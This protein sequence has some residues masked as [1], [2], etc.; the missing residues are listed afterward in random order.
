MPE[1]A[2]TLGM[3]SDAQVLVWGLKPAEDGIET[4]MVLRLWNMAS[5]AKEVRFTSTRPLSGALKA[6]HVETPSESVLLE[7]A[8]VQV[9]LAPQQLVTLL[10]VPDV[11]SSGDG[12]DSSGCSG[13]GSTFQRLVPRRLNPAGEGGGLSPAAGVGLCLGL[14][15]WR[16]RRRRQ[17]C[18]G[19]N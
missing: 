2:Y 15:L 12:G 1:A 6:S 14:G 4:G 13:M 3:T 7:G 5:S 11:S 16:L 9:S 10:L 8:T 18:P 17:G 19:S